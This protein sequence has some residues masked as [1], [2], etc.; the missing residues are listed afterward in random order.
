MR[1]KVICDFHD[2]TIGIPRS[3]G[4]VLELTEERFKEL[5]ELGKVVALPEQ[6]KLSD[7]LEFDA[8]KVFY[9]STMVKESFETQNRKFKKD[10][11]TPKKGRKS[12]K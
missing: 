10:P 5:K 7:G 11:I 12:S 1:A 9:T 4:Q 8:D 2:K 6:E 3:Y